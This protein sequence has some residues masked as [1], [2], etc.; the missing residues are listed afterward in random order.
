MEPGPDPR[1]HRSPPR[2]ADRLW[3]RLAVAAALSLLVHLALVLWGRPDFREV[4]D[5]AVEMDI[6]QGL[7]GRPDRGPEQ[8]SPVTDEEP[9]EEPPA[10][11]PK[12]PLPSPGA[13][14][15]VA[16][17]PPGI[18]ETDAGA[19][20]AG[21]EQALAA[22]DLPGDAGPG[23]GGGICL[24]DLFR[25]GEGRPSWLLWLSL[26]SFRGTE[27]Q[28]SLA[29]TLGAFGMYREMAGATGMDPGS[30]V[31]GLLVT[32]EDPFDWGSFRVVASYDSGEERLKSRLLS[33]RG[34]APGFSMHR[35]DQG[36]LAEVPGEYRWRLMGSGRVLA[37]ESAPPAPV[38][39]GPFPQAPRAPP[40][41]ALPPPD[42]P[43]AAPSP[44]AD[45][46]PLSLPDAGSAPP[47]APPAAEP[48]PSRR[49]PDQVTCLTAP[50]QGPLFAPAADL[51]DLGLSHLRPDDGGHWPV[52]L[53]A[54]SDARA[55]GLG[56]GRD[57]GLVFRFALVKGIFSDPV[58]IEGA[59]Y[60]E[61]VPEAL[62]ALARKW[63]EAAR[64]ARGDPLLGMV[65]LGGVFDGLRIEVAENR[66]E[67]ALPLTSGQVQAALLF[68]QL[69]GEAIERRI[70]RK[71]RPK[72]V[73]SISLA[74]L[75]DTCV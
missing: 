31:E 63:R 71:R 8:E 23:D 43:Y 34:R 5:F 4:A 11:P 73:R 46:G 24:H 62:G 21:P 30:E 1:G 32:A 66:I 49:F 12:A 64:Q 28:E 39:A 33:R 68:I 47:P 42:N 17:A 51:T 41:P 52:A 7:P 20:D 55:L 9:P 69:Q 44:L 25:F 56:F 14:E 74:T 72:P 13:G 67:F 26:A 45:A 40:P 57:P 18:G 22:A 53:L 38:T 36:Y 37:V 59:I 27:Y 29:A 54:T 50:A 2:K 15:A 61:A 16:E 65:G 70:E 60:I 10:P 48:A 35:T 19:A 58:R 6:V 3:H 75:P